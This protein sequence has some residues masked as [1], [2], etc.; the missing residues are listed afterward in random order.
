VSYQTDALVEI[1]ISRQMGGR[2]KKTK[3][4]A[5]E[6]GR[7]LHHKKIERQGKKRK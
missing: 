4:S 5:A 3:G 2:K 7:L 1:G 6:K